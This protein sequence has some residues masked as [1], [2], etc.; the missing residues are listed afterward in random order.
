MVYAFTMNLRQSLI[1]IP[2]T[3]IVYVSLLV[4]YARH[5]DA[6]Q[7][8]IQST[9]Y[10]S[11]D[12]A[13]RMNGR[14][15]VYDRALASPCALKLVAK[16]EKHAPTGGAYIET[17]NLHLRQPLADSLNWAPQINYDF[18]VIDAI[19]THCSTAK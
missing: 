7:K 19:I 6:Q 15:D 1:A 14:M 11:T 17:P 16:M 12:D 9:S 5:L 10:V 18:D 4:G 13:T 8:V 2:L 3:A